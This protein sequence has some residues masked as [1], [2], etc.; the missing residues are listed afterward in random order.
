MN[1]Y[2]P[3][4]NKITKKHLS[5]SALDQRMMIHTT[6]K[7]FPKRKNNYN[8]SKKLRHQNRIYLPDRN[9]KIFK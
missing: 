8:N 3:Y 4:I 7:K 5:L 6:S 9:P 1:S 2:Q